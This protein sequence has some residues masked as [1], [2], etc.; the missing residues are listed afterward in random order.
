[1]RQYLAVGYVSQTKGLNGEVKVKPLSDRKERFSKSSK[2]RISPPVE[3]VPFL[4]V[5]SACKHKDYFVVRFTEVRSIETAQALCGH[6]LEVS[7]DILKDDQYY[8][9]DLIGIEVKTDQGKYL[10]VI[11]EVKA[12]KAHDIYVVKNDKEYLI[13]AVKEIVKKIDIPKK[14]MV[15]TPTKGLLEL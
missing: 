2:L 13:P 4:T 14:I 7:A 10:G 3:N 5:K 8:V 11:T 1:M 6:Y 12:S 9:H 15:I